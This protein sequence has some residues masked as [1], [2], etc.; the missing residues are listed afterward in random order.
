MSNF[1]PKRYAVFLVIA[2]NDEQWCEECDTPEETEDIID[3]ERHRASGYAV[4]D[5]AAQAFTRTRNYLAEDY[6]DE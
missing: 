2:A 3:R 4:F 1:E 6:G 5:Q